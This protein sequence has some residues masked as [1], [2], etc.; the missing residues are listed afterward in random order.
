MNNQSNPQELKAKLEKEWERPGVRHPHH[1][2][3]WSDD[4]LCIHKRDWHC[5]SDTGLFHSRGRWVQNSIR[6]SWKRRR[7]S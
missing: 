2:T 1:L 5:S 4:P 7:K 3:R 6:R